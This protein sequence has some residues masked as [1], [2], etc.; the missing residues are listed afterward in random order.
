MITFR[1]FLFP[2]GP[3]RPLTALLSLRHRLDSPPRERDC[4]RPTRPDRRL[5]IRGG[6]KHGV[7]PKAPQA[8]EP[9][10]Y[11]PSRRRTEAAAR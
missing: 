11:L 4:E 2:L 6:K 10:L 7:P 1:L 8:E 3:K 9:R 5:D